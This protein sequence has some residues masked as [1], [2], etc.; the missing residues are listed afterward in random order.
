MTSATIEVYLFLA[1][2][3]S[4]DGAPEP[5]IVG[6]SAIP[7]LRYELVLYTK[8]ICTFRFLGFSFLGGVSS[9]QDPWR[10]KR[11]TMVA[12]PLP[13]HVSIVTATN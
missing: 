9:S 10:V 4:E 1:K 6:K 11:T 13:Q 3:F 8:A 2:M 12:A 7:V 5:K